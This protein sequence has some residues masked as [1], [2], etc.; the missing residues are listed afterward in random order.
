M[1]EI[2]KFELEP[3]TGEQILDMPSGAQILTVQTQGENICLWAEVD[4]SEIYLPK[5]KRTFI[6]HFTGVSYTRKCDSYMGTCT[7]DH[8]MFHVFERLQNES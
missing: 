3:Q 2:W 7:V 4:S 8:F 5:E 1:K 6:V